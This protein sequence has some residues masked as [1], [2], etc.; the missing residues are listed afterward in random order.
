M[1]S[2]FKPIKLNTRT[3]PNKVL[4]RGGEYSF[5]F[6]ER[7][8]DWQNSKVRKSNNKRLRK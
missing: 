3:Y 8:E 6:S 7:L 5:W 2:S 4:S 1:T